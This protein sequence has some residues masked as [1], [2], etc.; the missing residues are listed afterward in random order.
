MSKHYLIQHFILFFQT[1]DHNR[2]Q[3]KIM[4]KRKKSTK[5]KI[6]FLS[7]FFYFRNTFSR[8]IFEN[9]H[10]LLAC[11][12]NHHLQMRS[13]STI[14]RRR[15]TPARAKHNPIVSPTRASEC[16]STIILWVTISIRTPILKNLE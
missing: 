1:Q 5:I 6:N 11:A 14:T 12:S 4:K 7:F 2:N 9:P 3:K 16:T 15:V 13:S 8:L 10:H